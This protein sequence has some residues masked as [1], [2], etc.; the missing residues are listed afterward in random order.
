MVDHEDPNL[1]AQRYAEALVGVEDPLIAHIGERNLGMTLYRCGRFDEGLDH[2]DR[3][4]VHA[5]AFG[6]PEPR[7]RHPD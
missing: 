3:A 2:L 4:R 7:P 1:V 5:E 6:S